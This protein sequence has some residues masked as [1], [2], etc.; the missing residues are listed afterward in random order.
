M[1]WQGHGHSEFRAG[2]WKQPVK[3]GSVLF[4]TDVIVFCVAVLRIVTNHVFI[5]IYIYICWKTI[6]WVC[7]HFFVIKLWVFYL[8]LEVANVWCIVALYGFALDVYK[9]FELIVA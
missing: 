4:M 3:R 8:L 6:E 1:N 7:R 2:F 5:Y 9:E